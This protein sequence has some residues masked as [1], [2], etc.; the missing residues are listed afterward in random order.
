MILLM[1]QKSSVHQLR[2]VVYPTIYSVLDVPGGC[3]GF[4]P[5]TVGTKY[6]KTGRFAD[7]L[8]WV[9][10]PADLDNSHQ[11]DQVFGKVWWFNSQKLRGTVLW[12]HFFWLWSSEA[13]LHP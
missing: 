9:R 8:L 13:C 1:V 6:D 11:S 3:L 7:D 2:L 10:I 12:H 5:S 4:V